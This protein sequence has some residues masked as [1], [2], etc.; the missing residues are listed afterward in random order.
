MK[1]LI[2]EP[3]QERCLFLST[4][5]KV[6]G[7]EATRCETARAALGHFQQQQ[8]LLILLNQK[9]PDMDGLDLCRKLRTLRNGNACMILMLTEHEEP[10]ILK[11]ILEA[12]ADDYLIAP[13][14]A[15]LL[16]VRLMV[17][18]QE[19]QR[20]Y[21]RNQALKAL[22]PSLVQIEKAKQE[23]EA[24]ADSLTSI[25]CLLDSQGIIVRA[26]KAI[27]QWQLGKVLSIKGTS[28]HAL[29]HALCPDPECYFQGF[30]RQ[31]LE[32]VAQGKSVEHEVEDRI[33]HRH[34]HLQFRPIKAGTRKALKKKES[35]AVF[36]INDIS[37]RKQW[38][39]AELYQRMLLNKV[40][41]ALNVL[42][43][44]PD[45]QI[46]VTKALAILGA[47]TAV[48][49]VYI[50]KTHPH[51]DTREP[52]MSRLFEWV[53]K[54]TYTQ[55]ENPEWQNL[56]YND[57][58][59][60]WYK[61]LSES[62]VIS[63]LTKDFPV[64]EQAF[65]TSQGTISTLLVPIIM[66]EQ[67][68]GGMGFDTCQQARLWR[69]E[70]TTILSV[71]ATSIGGALLHKQTEERFHQISTELRTVFQSLPDEYFRLSANGSL[72]DYKVEQGAEAPLSRT[73]IIKWAA[74]LLPEEIE[75]QFDAAIARVLKS[76]E[77]AA[78]TFWMP[79]TGDEPRKY[80]EVRVFPFL[81]DQV[82]VVV[83]DMTN[84]KLNT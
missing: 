47:A 11:S 12:G 78:V 70:E 30:L 43:I 3:D 22:Q 52:A 24:T 44:A 77:P 64:T 27:E 4:Q 59:R 32:K 21:Q 2:V 71:A 84:W 48:D 18:D 14:R 66:N 83:R 60:R 62:R 73:F 50:F 10:Q 1:I 42:L 23:W 17:L 15:E 76:K 49:R 68:W 61:T 29:L 54:S 79:A 38:E 46:G 36:M 33:L 8:F 28:A 45:F 16:K 81:E 53:H 35:F 58:L 40:A 63:G 55:I 37:E 5:L 34:L 6:F 82:L 56:S 25:V 72:L 80:Q 75:R 7:H 41:N 39:N 26:N 65:L 13:V 20:L 74:K 31:A 19:L 9:L 67:L 57:R 69:E 51:P